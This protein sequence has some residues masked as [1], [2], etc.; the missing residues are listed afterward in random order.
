MPR[1]IV[2]V[3]GA[4]KSFRTY[5]NRKGFFGSLR[6][7]SF[8]KKALKGVSLNVKESEVV[9]LL[10]RNG[11][12]KSTMIKLMSGILYPDSGSIKVLGMDPWKERTKLAMNIGVVFGSTHPQLFWDLPPL[13]TFIYVKELYGISQKDYDSRLAYLKKILSIDNVYKRQTR[14]LSLGER[15]K[16]EF[17][18]SILHMPKIVFMDEPTVGVDL[19]SRMAISRAVIDLREKFG[20]TFV[21][22]THVVDDIAIADRIILLDKGMKLFDGKQE[23][24]K[25][26][27]GKYAILELYFKPEAKFDYAKYESL[28][29][30]FSKKDGYI[31]LKVDP[32]IT[33]SDAFASIFEDGNIEDYRLS[34]PGL[35]SILESTYKYIDSNKRSEE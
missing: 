27:F 3:K 15:M 23:E 33:K 20:I 16:C 4:V 9:A 31:G 7:K 12:G 8:M 6:R 11:S 28:G 22:T 10:G 5:E 30:V 32:N 24:L 14:Q 1:S 35:S 21:L 34:E 17:T 25:K 19:P 13:D 18:A 2:E 26:R 29:K